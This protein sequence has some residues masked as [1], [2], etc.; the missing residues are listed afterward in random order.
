M[1]PKL[2]AAPAFACGIIGI[3]TAYMDKWFFLALAVAAVGAVLGV[4]ALKGEASVSDKGMAVAGALASAFA[5]CIALGSIMGY[6]AAYL[7]A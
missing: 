1:T 4:K 6:F 5:L 3:L 2:K 7:A